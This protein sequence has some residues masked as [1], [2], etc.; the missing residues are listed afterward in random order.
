MPTCRLLRMSFTPARKRDRVARANRNRCL[1]LMVM[2]ST[3]GLCGFH[4]LQQ[5]LSA[6]PERNED[7]IYF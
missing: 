1:L 4:Q 6:I 3:A 7:F 2:S 5:L